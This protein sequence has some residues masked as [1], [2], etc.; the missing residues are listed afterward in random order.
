MGGCRSL[1]G[2][3]RDVEAA[4]EEAVASSSGKPRG[5]TALTESSSAVFQRPGVLGASWHSQRNEPVQ[6]RSI[7]SMENA[8]QSND[9]AFQHQCK[10]EPVCSIAS[11]S[12]FMVEFKGDKQR[13]SQ[14]W[15]VDVFKDV[16]CFDR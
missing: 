6:S 4:C 9:W 2:L 7:Y 14:A 12:N 13:T 3:R 16:Q 5:R 8:A 10:I 1:H 11:Y 15:Y